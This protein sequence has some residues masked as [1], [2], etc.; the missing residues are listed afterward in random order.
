MPMHLHVHL[1]PEHTEQASPAMWMAINASEGKPYLA[2]LAGDVA[3][4][5]GEG[6][7][8]D[9]VRDCGLAIGARRNLPLCLNVC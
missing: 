9:N 3:M 1:P 7:S 2:A 6:A 5:K 4:L 8:R